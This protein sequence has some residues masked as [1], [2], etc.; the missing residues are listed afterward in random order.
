VRRHN[1]DVTSLVAG[2]VFVTIGLV[3]ALAGDPWNLLA[4]RIDWSWLGP[5]VLIG[6]GAAVMLPVLRRNRAQP[7]HPGDAPAL[8]PNLE[9]AHDELPPRTMD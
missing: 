1:L 3:F 4:F 9:A 7:A 5:V 8:D 6:I 2:A